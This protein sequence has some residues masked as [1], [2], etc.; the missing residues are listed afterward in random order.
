[1]PSHSFKTLAEAAGARMLESG[2]GALPVDTASAIG[3]RLARLIGPRTRADRIARQNIARLGLSQETVDWAINAAWDNVGRTFFEYPH[4]RTIIRENRVELRGREHLI[5]AL[6]AG[7]GGLLVAGHFSNWEVLPLMA[8]AGGIRLTAMQRPPNNPF[9]RDVLA[10]CRP[11]E[12]VDYIEKGRDGTR[13]TFDVLRNGGFFGFLM[14]QRYERGIEVN[15]LDSTIAVAPTVGSLAHKFRCPVLMAQAERLGG[16][17]FR[18]TV[19]PPMEVDYDQDR[20]TFQRTVAQ[21]AMSV[22]EGWIRERPEQWFW[23]HRLWRNVA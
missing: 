2:I 3:G 19:S 9:V 21:K 8:I 1:M 6:N 20:E 10:R 17:H 4:L 7:K 16:V 22:V 5:N 13:I 18:V 11:A 12:L 14:D 23:M 15:F